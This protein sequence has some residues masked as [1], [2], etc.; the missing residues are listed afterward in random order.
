MIGAA[1]RFLAHGGLG[2]DALDEPGAVAQREEMNLAARPAV[3]QPAAE[4]D[5][6]A[7]VRG[8][9]FDVDVHA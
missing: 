5:G 7:G 9:V 3:V 2:H 4:G 1:E 8:N 6:F